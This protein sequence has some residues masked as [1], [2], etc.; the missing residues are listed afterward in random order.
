M[1]INII[2]LI[3]LALFTVTGF[4]AIFF[5]TFGTLIIMAGAVI[6]SILTGFS[7]ISLKTLILLF[8][9]YLVGEAAEYVFLIAGAKKF[10]ASNAAAGGALVGGI[11]GAVLGVPILGVGIIVGAF[12]GI[13]LGAFLVELVL[14]R[15]M[16]I[17]LKAGA[18]GVLGRMGSIAAK[19]V[20][21]LAMVMIMA[22][23]VIAN[24]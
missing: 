5:T 24:Y 7:V 22:N 12:L 9:L 3:I 8:V 1:L 19:V 20:I 18:G 11:I 2:S 10:G 14:R 16:L 4:A 6:Y 23:K 17:S 13:F 21:A 15:N